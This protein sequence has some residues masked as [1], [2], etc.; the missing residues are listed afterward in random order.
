MID[1]EQNNREPFKQ[2]EHTNF[3]EEIVFWTLKYE[4]SRQM[5]FLLFYM[6]PDANFKKGLIEAFCVL[7]SMKTHLM[8]TTKNHETISKNL[9][10]IS[11]RLFGNEDLALLVV[12]QQNMLSVTLS[13]LRNM[14]NKILVPSTLHSNKIL[15]NF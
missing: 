13:N 14:M 6:L 11:N 9:I 12:N 3:L 2:I 1:N 10:Y 5:T 8:E 7:Y 4:F 15:N